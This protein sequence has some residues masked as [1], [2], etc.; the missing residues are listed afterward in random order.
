[1]V[2][3]LQRVANQMSIAIKKTNCGISLRTWGNRYDRVRGVRKEN[4]VVDFQT[5]ALESTRHSVYLRSIGIL[6]Q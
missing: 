6:Y 1:M 5:M 4:N 2:S 3:V